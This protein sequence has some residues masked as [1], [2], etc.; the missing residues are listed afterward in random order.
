MFV[1]PACWLLAYQMKLSSETRRAYQIIY[2]RFYSSIV[3][4]AIYIM[5]LILFY[6]SFLLGS[7]KINMKNTFFL[8]QLSILQ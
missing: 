6:F 4:I 7:R 1:F 3:Y 8:K 5:H 2:L